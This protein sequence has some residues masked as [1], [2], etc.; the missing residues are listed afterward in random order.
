MT[1]EETL[2]HFNKDEPE[3]DWDKTILAMKA[4]ARAAAE[5]SW[6]AAID[7]MEDLEF[8]NHGNP[9]SKEQYINTHYG[10]Q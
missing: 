3:L 6:D 5:L 1:V 10:Q 2:H 4:Y 7:Y 9:P 8:S